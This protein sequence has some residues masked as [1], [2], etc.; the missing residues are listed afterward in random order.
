MK[1]YIPFLALILALMLIGVTHNSLA[2][3]RKTAS[4]KVTCTMGGKFKHSSSNAHIAR[5]STSKACFEAELDLFQKQRG[6][7]PDDE[8]ADLM[9]EN[10]VNETTC[11]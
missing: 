1:W 5:Q 4:L 6:Q 9:I 7:L 8:Q 10:C 11:I 2:S 3:T